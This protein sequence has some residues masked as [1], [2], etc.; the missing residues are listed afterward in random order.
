MDAAS[1]VVVEQICRSLDGLPLAIEL[2]AA[3]TRSLSVPEIA[4]RLDNRFA[5][6][7]DPTS[8][9]PE[10]RRALEA[11]I[12][13]SYGLLFPDD[14]RGLW[15]LSAFAGGAPLDAAEEAVQL[16]TRLGD[17]W[18]LLHPE[19]M[20]ARS[21]RP[22][23]A[24]RTQRGPS[25]PRQR[26]RS[27]WSSPARRRFI[28]PRSAGWSSDAATAAGL[29]ADADQVFEGIPHLLDESD[30]YEASRACAAR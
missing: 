24:S 9:A 30:R 23:T 2:A 20:R 6:L 8:R 18:G 12:G 11:A 1:A 27:G 4:R 15:A 17:A 22:G 29:L 28:S 5:L 26:Q 16:L 13:W 14:Q 3:R 21:P 25:P 10:R 19:A 7:R